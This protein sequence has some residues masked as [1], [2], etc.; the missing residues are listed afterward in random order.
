MG[1]Y[2]VKP[3]RGTA[4]QEWPP[5][6]INQLC[7]CRDHSLLGSFPSQSGHPA[8]GRTLFG[9]N[10]SMHQSPRIMPS[11]KDNNEAIP[12]V[13]GEPPAHKRGPRPRSNSSIERPRGGVDTICRSA[14]TIC[15]AIQGDMKNNNDRQKPSTHN[16]QPSAAWHAFCRPRAPRLRHPRTTERSSRGSTSAPV[17]DPL[18][19]ANTT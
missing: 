3:W 14:D 7:Q 11:C 17:T 19:S 10:R 4:F 13:F 18:S 2:P 12:S 1:A 9:P 15:R 16:L 5:F 8:S 6:P